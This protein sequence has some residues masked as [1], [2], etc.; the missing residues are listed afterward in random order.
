MRTIPARS[1]WTKSN[2]EGMMASLR[3]AR[4]RAL[5]GTMPGADWPWV[6]KD[7]D[8]QERYVRMRL[9]GQSHNMAEILATGKFPGTRTDV[10][11][12]R[13]H[14]NGNQ[15]AENPVQSKIGDYYRRLAEESGQSTTGKV[16]R[17]GLA[18]FPGDPR[19]WVSTRGEAE[20]YVRETGRSCH[21]LV[22]VEA[23]M[24]DFPDDPPGVDPRLIA[25]EVAARAETD[26]MLGCK[27]PIELTEK[28]AELRRPRTEAE[29]IRSDER[30]ADKIVEG[31]I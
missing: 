27:T 16:Y 19:A 14:V 6:S 28:L 26:Q 21:G 11:W 13:G 23:P 24:L 17:S 12:N 18:Q 15:F 29:A 5:E 7:L 2:I 9:E 25:A 20:Q 30:F 3:D 31:P 1:W 10:E 22:N 4:R 8:R